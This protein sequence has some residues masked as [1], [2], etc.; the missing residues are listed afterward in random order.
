[1]YARGEVLSTR[2]LCSEGYKRQMEETYLAKDFVDEIPFL[3]TESDLG[4][5]FPA[6]TLGLYRAWLG[7]LRD[8]AI[9][10][11]P[12]EVKEAKA[13]LAVGEFTDDD[14]ATVDVALHLGEFAA[15]ALDKHLRGHMILESST[16]FVK[17]INAKAPT[18]AHE[19]NTADYVEMI[20]ALADVPGRVVL[21]KRMLTRDYTL[22]RQSAMK[23]KGS[24]F[25]K[26][27]QA[28]AA[29]ATWDVAAPQPS[30]DD[31]PLA[32]LTFASE[33]ALDY[34][35]SRLAKKKWHGVLIT[36]S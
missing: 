6:Q 31:C 10:G 11:E 35:G 34:F 8:D 15:L 14:I 4:I 25:M 19:F 13:A 32:L 18:V 16:A 29:V 22:W 2:M 20:P 17:R 12:L 23:A 24:R 30:D 9:K 26:M 36:L 7:A 33:V 5:T 27:G 28:L 21:P 3:A 1:M